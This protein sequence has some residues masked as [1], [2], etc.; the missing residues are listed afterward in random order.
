MSSTSSN[1]YSINVYYLLDG[2]NILSCKFIPS[3]AKFVDNMFEISPKKS[4][5]STIS[6]FVLSRDSITTAEQNII[7]QKVINIHAV[8]SKEFSGLLSIN[9]SLQL[10]LSYNSFSATF[11]TELVEN[12]H[13]KLQ[14]TPECFITSYVSDRLTIGIILG[15]PFLSFYVFNGTD[16]KPHIFYYIPNIAPWIDWQTS[17]VLDFKI[18]KSKAYILVGTSLLDKNSQMG[19]L[20]ID[21]SSNSS[22]SPATRFIDD[23]LYK[24]KSEISLEMYYDSLYVDY[25][26]NTM[27]AGFKTQNKKYTDIPHVEFFGLYLKPEY[28]EYSSV[29]SYSGSNSNCLPS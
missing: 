21:L 8:E 18:Y 22:K 16:L 17:F 24:N 11:T 10:C 27:M 7:T 2:C 20:T 3:S 23:I 25:C 4:L 1:N 26:S 5:I 19:L 6:N 14:A 15:N 29:L 9:N 12:F 28:D 13:E